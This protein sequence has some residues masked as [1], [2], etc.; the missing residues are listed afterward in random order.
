VADSFDPV[1]QRMDKDFEYWRQSK[2]IRGEQEKVFA[3][4]GLAKITIIVMGAIAF[5]VLGCFQ[6]VGIEDP[7]IAGGIVVLLLTAIVM[8]SFYLAKMP[9]N[10]K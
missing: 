5:P 3:A 9:S 10:S 8:A 1:D 7:G 6:A 4:D 2:Y